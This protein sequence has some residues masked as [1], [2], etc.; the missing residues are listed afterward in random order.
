QLV[1]ETFGHQAHYLAASSG[2][3]IQGVLPFVSMKSRLFGQFLVSMPF[4]SYG[5]VL[6]TTTEARNALLEE[7]AQFGQQTGARYVGMRQGGAGD[8]RW[9]DQTPKVT[10]VVELPYTVEGLWN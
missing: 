4:S 9:L 6:A 5:G 8:V 2:G 10:M 7:A 1:E 3:A